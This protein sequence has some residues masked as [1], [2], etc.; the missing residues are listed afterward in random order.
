MAEQ[1]TIDLKAEFGKLRQDLEDVTRELIQI[2]EESAASMKKLDKEA[3]KTSKGVK[4]LGKEAQKTS[5]GVKKLGKAF[6]GI[7]TVL[8]GGALK[9]GAVLFEKIMEIFLF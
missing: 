9:L 5:K 4:K 6:T 3:Q 2:K 1:I 8:T 7:G